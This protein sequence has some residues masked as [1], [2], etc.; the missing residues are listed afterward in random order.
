MSQVERRGRRDFR[1]KQGLGTAA[2]HFTDDLVAK[3][4]IVGDSI[5]VE[6]W[7]WLMSLVLRMEGVGFLHIPSP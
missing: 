6:R 2:P 3:Y 7:P 5:S 1:T 4:G